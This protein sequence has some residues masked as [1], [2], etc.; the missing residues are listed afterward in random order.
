MVMMFDKDYKIT[1]D[2]LTDRNNRDMQ[3]LIERH[4]AWQ[5]DGY[6]RGVGLALL[7][8]IRFLELIKGHRRWTYWQRGV[9]ERMKEHIKGIM[10]G[11]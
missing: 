11:E 9:F 10:E 6:S 2:P 7:R 5:M 1:G 4:I 3:S 8:Q